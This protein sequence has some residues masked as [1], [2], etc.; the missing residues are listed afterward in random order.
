MFNFKIKCITLGLVI[1]LPACGGSGGGSDETD[2]SIIDPLI[3]DELTTPLSRFEWPPT[4][5]TYVQLASTLY[6]GMRNTFSTL[7]VAGELSLFSIQFL[8]VEPTKSCRESG[9]KTQTINRQNDSS[10]TVGDFSNTVFS[11]CDDNDLYTEDGVLNFSL[12]GLEGEYNY[13]NEFALRIGISNNIN[14]TNDSVENNNGLYKYDLRYTLSNMPGLERGDN[15]DFTIINANY[16]YDGV[17]P[18]AQVHPFAS[19]IAD[20]IAFPPSTPDNFSE[21]TSK[22]DNIAFEWINDE[23]GDDTLQTFHWKTEVTDLLDERGSFTFETVTP[24]LLDERV[25][26]GEDNGFREFY[27]YALDGELLIVM[28]TNERIQIKVDKSLVAP[29]ATNEKSEVPNVIISFDAGAD[30]EY[31]TSVIMTWEDFAIAFLGS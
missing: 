9:T 28:D 16:L 15:I 23:S 31:E 26:I 13:E 7:R 20:D 25:R 22:F 10:L 30:G 11:L 21:P 3:G 29:I 1:I 24:L 17:A 2:S 14:R 8:D 5:E 6:Q 27:D 12:D 19:V 18:S 4:D